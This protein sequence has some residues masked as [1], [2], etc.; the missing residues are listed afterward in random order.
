[1]LEISVLPQN[2]PKIV[3][4]SAPIFALLD[5][6]F[7]TII[8]FFEMEKSVGDGT[9]T[10]TRTIFAMIYFFVLVLIIVLK[11]F[12][13]FCFRYRY[14]YPHVFV[15]RFVIADE[16]IIFSLLVVYVIIITAAVKDVTCI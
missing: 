9:T 15:N 7:P 6:Y 16:F 5:R 1:M 8:K 13:R 11:L 4:R 3:R 12:F 2:V 14:R 10:T